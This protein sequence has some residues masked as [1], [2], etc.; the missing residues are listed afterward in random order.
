MNLI[1]YKQKNA[2][3]SVKPI[4]FSTEMVKAKLEGRKTQTRRTKGL[5]AVNINPDDWQFEW[6][7]FVLKKP[8]RFTKKSSVNEQTLADRSFH[9]E[10]VACPYGN[11]GDILWVRE[12]WAKL[13]DYPLHEQFLYIA[14]DKPTPGTKWK[15]SIH[16][17]FEAARIFLRVKSV[18]VE[19][20]QDISDDDVM[21]EGAE[22]KW[23]HFHELVSA[24]TERWAVPAFA[25]LWT[26]INGQS[27]W[28]ANPWVW[29]VEF[30]RIT[31]SQNN[32]GT[33]NFKLSD[34]VIMKNNQLEG[35]IVNVNKKQNDYQVQFNDGSIHW[36]FGSELQQK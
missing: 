24:P 5:E 23:F 19:R 8:W 26:S 27:S 11:P 28:N 36:L 6:A 31:E 16:M 15:P 25:R 4:L 35:T 30:E 2:G 32:I 9:Q 22:D 13:S 3:V 34:T 14:T 1:E 20:L 7:D 21:H 17:P 12:T 33:N 10:A 29:V 18:R